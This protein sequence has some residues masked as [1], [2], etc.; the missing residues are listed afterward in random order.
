[1][2]I[3]ATQILNK[4]VFAEE[5]KEEVGQVLEI[6]I[7]PE[8]GQILGFL[9][10]QP[11][12]K[13]SVVSNMDVLDISNDAIVINSANSLISPSEIIK[14]QEILNQKIKILGARA[15]TES[16]KPLGRI[17][18]FIIETETGSL[19]KFYIKSGFFSPL[20]ILPATSVLKI[21]KN[22][23]IFSDDVLTSP[24]ATEA[25]PT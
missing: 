5:E 3:Q 16:K 19:M 1:M 10:S 25:V 23:V 20:L 18:D 8:N 7:D 17:E 4:P 11:F 21:E 15:E 22:K 9:V 24:K 13:P 12:A 14:I 2:F 6:I